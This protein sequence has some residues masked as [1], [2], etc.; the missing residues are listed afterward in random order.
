M[1][2]PT[3]RRTLSIKLQ[4]FNELA[5][6]KSGGARARFGTGSALRAEI[7]VQRVDSGVQNQVAVRAAFQMVL[8]LAFN[9]R[10]EPSL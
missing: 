2:I 5:M 1:P 3:V 7:L 9:G 8:D 6:E 10:G 4:S